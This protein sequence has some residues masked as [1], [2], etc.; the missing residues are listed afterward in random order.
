MSQV[1]QVKTPVGD[2]KWVVFTGEGKENMS[3]RMKYQADL[4]LPTDSEEAQNLKGVI[5]QYWADNRPSG[6]PPKKPAKSLGYRLEKEPILDDEG[7]KQYDDEGK[8]VSKETG[9]TV[10]TFSTDTTY[11]SGDQKVINIFNAKG[12][13][14]DLGSKKI[15]NG[16]RGQ[17]SGAIGIYTVKDKAGKNISDA[18]VTLYLNSIRLTKF[19]EFSGEES[20]DA[21]D[22]GDGWTGEG[23]TDGWEGETGQEATG[24]KGTPRL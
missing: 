3:G 2:L 10:F 20:W 14:V 5:D 11:P 8:V 23:E 13:K 7:N 17:L 9:N 19:V 22:D 4:V 18:G 6:L 12:N 21:V 15:G 16:S 24:S 1:M